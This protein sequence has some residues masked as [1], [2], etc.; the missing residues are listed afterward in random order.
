MDLYIDEAYLADVTVRTEFGGYKDRTDLTAD[1]LIDLLK[2]PVRAV[3][4]GS[5]DHPEFTKLREQLGQQGF[6]KIER[7]WNN[8]DCVLKPFRLNGV[9][10]KKHD[11]FPCA[12]AMKGHLKFAKLYQQKRKGGQDA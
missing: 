8:G 4:I 6:I 2:N 5:K 7:S 3:M 10:F 12:V 9:K 11:Q 1:E